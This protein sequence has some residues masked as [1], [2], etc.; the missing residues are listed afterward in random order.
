M[1][2]AGVTYESADNLAVLPENSSEAVL[3]I[4]AAMGYDQ[5]EFF[6]LEPTDPSNTKF[7]HMFPTPCTVSDALRRYCDIQCI[8]RHATMCHLV[9][10]VTDAK[11]K[12]WLENITDKANRPQFKSY[13]EEGGRSLS[14]LLAKGGELSSCRVP[15]AD[16]LHITPRLQPRYYTISSSSNVHP[17]SIHITVALTEKNLPDG[18]KFRG[19]CSADLVAHDPAQGLA[20]AR[21][22]VRPSTFRLPESLSTPVLMIG[23]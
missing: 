1:Y 5:D 18:R 17:R 7:K 14:V 23:E 13:I 9:P 16:F 4:C 6:V 2:C 20:P 22:F 8:P 15:L 3:G 21:V 19:V 11:Q 12:A 10:Y